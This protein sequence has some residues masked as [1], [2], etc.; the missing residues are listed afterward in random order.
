MLSFKTFLLE[1]IYYHGRP[2]GIEGPE[3]IK[4]YRNF[5]TADSNYYGPGAYMG[6]EKISASGYAE[7]PRGDLV[8]DYV[9]GELKT[10]K[11]RPSWQDPTILKTDI[12]QSEIFAPPREESIKIKTD[13]IK[14]NPRLAP[15]ADKIFDVA[16]LNYRHHFKNFNRNNPINRS[17]RNQFL[18]RLSSSGY[19]A[20]GTISDEIVIPPQMQK[21]TTLT[22]DSSESGKDIGK[23]I[24]LASKRPETK[25]E[26]MMRDMGVSG[27]DPIRTSASR[28]S[29]HGTDISDQVEQGLKSAQS[30]IPFEKAKSI[31]KTNIVK[32]LKSGIGKALKGLDIFSKVTN[33]AGELLDTGV[34]A[35][36]RLGTGVGAAI[37]APLMI[38]QET[39]LRASP[40]QEIEN[41]DE[42]GNTV[43]TD[44]W[45]GAPRYK[46]G[47]EFTRRGGRFSPNKEVKKQLDIMAM[48]P[49]PA[50]QMSGKKQDTFKFR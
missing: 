2:K 49:N 12:D 48:T 23:T 10:F 37:T 11:K 9:D 14:N 27:V 45:G 47:S 8:T 1:A 32:P 17:A 22:V 50:E 34:G 38:N 13:F 19:K 28:Y 42:T 46:V 5:T 36:T 7:M 15:Y 40:Y 31:V 43:V 25:A 41:E 18:R 30:Q 20:L 29:P 39:S 33:P 4:G 3:D 24:R 6:P 35:A 44:T 16:G 21:N 26:K